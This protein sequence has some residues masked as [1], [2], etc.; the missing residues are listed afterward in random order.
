MSCAASSSSISALC[1][2]QKKSVSDDKKPDRACP[3]WVTYR[4]GPDSW[5]IV[6]RLCEVGRKAEPRITLE[7]NIQLDSATYPDGDSQCLETFDCV[8]Y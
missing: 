8:I 7:E 4:I 6:G 5:E 1:L 2:K 3:I